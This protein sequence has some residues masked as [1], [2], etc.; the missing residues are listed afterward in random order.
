MKKF[1]LL[2]GALALALAPTFAGEGEASKSADEPAKKCCE[3]G[4]EFCEEC[5]DDCPPEECVAKVSEKLAAA[6]AVRAEAAVALKQLPEEQRIA[7]EADM[8]FLK[9]NCPGCQAF[10]GSVQ[11]TAKLL[12]ATVAL[13]KAQGVSEAPNARIA[14]ELATSLGEICSMMGCA[15]CASSKPGDEDPLAR[16]EAAIGA[17]QGALDGWAKAPEAYQ[18]MEPEKA[19][20]LQET[21]KRVEASCPCFKAMGES[22]KSLALG[23]KVLGVLAAPEAKDAKAAAARAQCVELAGKI[24]AGMCQ[25]DE[26]CSDDGEDDDDDA[27]DDEDEDEDEDECPVKG[28]KAKEAA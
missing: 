1:H 19:A 3:G 16:S 27:D 22:M 9:E 26:S 14:A 7:I 8:K 21:L 15:E 20:K 28:E 24:V 11:A 12:A 17:G 23:I 13:D 10:G 18:K 2:A 4:C 25:G 5:C 6:R